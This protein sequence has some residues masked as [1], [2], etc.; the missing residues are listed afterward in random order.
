[1]FQHPHAAER[2]VGPDRDQQMD[3]TGI[4]VGHHGIEN[5]GHR[6]IPVTHPI[7]R[8][9]HPAE[10]AGIVD[11][12]AVAQGVVVHQRRAIGSRRKNGAKVGQQGLALVG[13]DALGRQ[14]LGDRHQADAS[15]G[16]GAEDGAGG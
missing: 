9:A 8:G 5:Q 4:A 2:A 10:Q 13:G 6:L 15:D 7:D 11:L 14:G 16:E 3:R 12:D 1:M